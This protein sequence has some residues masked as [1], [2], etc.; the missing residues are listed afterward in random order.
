MLSEVDCGS[1]PALPHTHMLWNKSSRMGTEVIYQCV[2]GYHNAGGGNMSTCTAA[3]RWERPPILCQGTVAAFICI[4]DTFAFL[5]SGLN[6][7][8]LRAC[9]MVLGASSYL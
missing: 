6:K 1:P 5:L 8:E 4:F 2:Y 7:V 3:G 9:Y